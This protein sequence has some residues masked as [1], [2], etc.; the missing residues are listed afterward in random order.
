M[1]EGMERLRDKMKAKP[2]RVIWKSPL[3]REVTFQKGDTLAFTYD[4]KSRTGTV[5][6]FYSTKGVVRGL[7][8]LDEDA[9]R[10]KRY[11]FE[12]IVLNTTE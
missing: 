9:G 4:D 8:M 2:S 1:L 6:A 10:P 5:V 3:G 7:V 12:K 11:A